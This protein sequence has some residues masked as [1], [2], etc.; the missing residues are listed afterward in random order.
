[1]WESHHQIDRRWEGKGT[2][3]MNHIWERSRHQNMTGGVAIVGA[4]R[5]WLEN[6]LSHANLEAACGLQARRMWWC[7]KTHVVAGGSDERTT[8]LTGESR[9][10]W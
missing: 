1:M 10:S 5:W 4:E 2:T 8:M 6:V 7:V 3:S 9:G